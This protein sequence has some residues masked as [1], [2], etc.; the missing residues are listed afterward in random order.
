MS[1]PAD[2]DVDTV[3]VGNGPSSMILSYILHGHIPYYTSDSNTPHPD[4][5]LHAK[6]KD[7]PCLL[8]PDLD[9][10]T[11]H[12]GA[13]LL[14]Y[15]T[16]ALPINVLLDTL[17]RPQGEVDDLGE[18]TNLKWIHIPHRAV[19][20]IVV[21]NAPNPGGLWAMH[22]DD[23]V[24]IS[25]DIG[26]LSYAGMLSLPGYTFADHYRKTT[27]GKELAPF[28]R[29]SRRELA[30]YLRAYPVQAGIADSFRDNTE[31][32]GIQRIDGGFYIPS[33]RI[34][35]KH[36]VL[37]SGIFS[38]LIQPPPLLAPLLELPRNGPSGFPL[39]VVGSGFTAADAI[40]SAPSGQHILHTFL[41]NPN[42]RPSPLKSCHQQAY[43]EYAGIYRLMKRAALSSSSRAGGH[44]PNPR[45]LASTSFLESRNWDHIYEGLPN[46]SIENVQLKEDHAIITLVLEDG[47]KLSRP[48]CGLVYGVG[49]RGSLNYLSSSLRAEV[50]HNANPSTDGVISAKTLRDKVIEDL[51]VAPDVFVIGSLTGDSLIRFAYGGCVYAAYSLISASGV[52]SGLC[53]PK[54]P[55]G[56]PTGGRH[57]LLNGVDGHSMQQVTGSCRDECQESSQPRKRS[58]WSTIWSL[59]F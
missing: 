5:L 35:C 55:A 20:H 57:A 48:V 18:T 30:E 12:F 23:P 39:L 3:I 15:S 27:K 54:Q 36:L 47:T 52:C 41:W 58:W 28:T 19:S 10:L 43:P 33:H 21:G 45:R 59:L 44:R 37:A 26:T 51:E 25:W 11:C 17:L 29:P 50:L 13:S 1:P 2:V 46:C 38:H 4:S 31:L 49:R 9:A 14:S 53:T 8:R 22:T 42:D 32:D 7:S 16:Q 56:T 34:R 6:L 24:N 40:I